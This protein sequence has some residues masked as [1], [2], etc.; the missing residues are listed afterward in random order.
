[1][2]RRTLRNLLGMRYIPFASFLAFLVARTAPGGETK[3]N[4]H[5]FTLRDGFVVEMV[6]GPPLVDRPIVADF[7]EE[8]RLFVAD[9]AGTNDKVEKQLQE[10]PHR[11]VRLE[12]SDGDGRFDR[13]TVFADKMM[14]PEGVLC[15]GG[16]VFVGA[17]P[18]IWRLED[19][20]GD[21]VA[22][23][24]TEWFAGKVLTG[25]AN[26]IH[27]PYLGLDGRIYWTKGGFGKQDIPRP[28]K[29]PITDSASHIYRARPDGSD[30]ESFMTGGMDNPVEVVFTPEGEPIFTTTFYSHPKAGER[31][32]LVHA[33]WG[34]L[35]P[36][37]HGILDGLVR[38]GDLLPPITHLGP[39][40]PSGLALY[41]SRVFG[42]E[43]E[44]NLFS[45]LFNLRKIQRHVLEPAGSTF[46]SRDEDFL[47]SDNTDFHATDVLEDADGSLLVL[48]T[49]GW[50]KLCCPSAQIARPDALGAIYRIRRAGAP[51]IEDARGCKLAWKTLAATGLVRLLGDERP[52]V[53]RRA[54][55]EFEHAGVAAVP[56]LGTVFG[57]PNSAPLRCRAVWA[58]T[59]IETVAARAA[60]QMALRD[61]DE[62]V[63]QAA[64]H[65]AGL[66]RDRGALDALID[67]LRT[68]SPHLRRS[69][70]AAI[71]RIGDRSAVAPLLQAARTAG[72]RFL[73]HA[74]TYALIEIADKEGTAV[75]LRSE[76]VAE[77]RTA[78]IALDQITGGSLAA[79]DVTPF[80]FAADSGLQQTAWWI[81]RRHPEWGKDVAGSIREKLG[82]GRL[83]DAEGGTIARFLP[84]MASGGAIQELIG[85]LAAAE[86]TPAAARR[87]ILRIMASTPLKEAPVAWTRALVQ[88]LAGKEEDQVRSAIAAARAVPAPKTEAAALDA[89]L[90][91]VAKGAGSAPDLR[92]EALG[93]LKGDIGAVDPELFGFLASFLTNKLRPGESPRAR[94]EA[95]AILAKAKLSD[96]QLLALAEA[97]P[98]AGPIEFPSLLAAY[99]GS[100]NETVGRKL[101][102]SLRESKG[103]ASLRPDRLKETLGKFPEPVR[104]AGQELVGL[105]DL[106]PAAQ[107][108]RLDDLTGS[109]AGGDAGRGK[110]VFNHPKAACS[111]CHAIG[112]LGGNAGPDLTRIGSVRA[113][114]DL[115]ESLVFP[116]ASFVR[117]YEPVTITTREGAIHSGVLRHESADS[118]LIVSAADKEQR[119]STGEIREMQPG[120]VSI[121]PQGL[122]AQLTSQEMADL[123]AFLRSLK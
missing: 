72:D 28:G 83:S 117:S 31:D 1:M 108:A 113:D 4:G 94:S 27:G 119:F 45:T 66:H 70:A 97:I 33:V 34:G 40:V 59:R 2:P 46:R 92:L 116:S 20:D 88:S 5:T 62:T 112:Y 67:A 118:V 53:R 44:G 48:D 49:G 111:A 107:K 7:D 65:S 43:F 30:I 16:A 47:V 78:L 42:D 91:S 55:A 36:K 37:E 52:A 101:V 74:I 17:P 121:M 122:D 21:G 93:A 29:P 10:R 69:A 103:L 80:L 18:S 50:Y 11:I 68:G 60:V 79:S 32:A 39:A 89:A 51:A 115:L 109:L 86:A 114:R 58:L 73:D 8:G 9:S 98:A 63:R 85:E 35:Y 24:R 100:T 104:D 15:H 95:A 102:E 106:N 120:T 87:L 110:A 84:R 54:M 41:A 22:D 71:G 25:C 77:R 57:T 99:A 19:S 96:E 12:D 81:A 105:L 6:A 23:K 38:T 123:I 56:I 26:D 64:A 3:L 76:N 61:P 13:S 90:R 75:G 14:F 82:G